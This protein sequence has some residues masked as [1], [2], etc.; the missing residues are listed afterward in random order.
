[1]G[2]RCSGAAVPLQPH[3]ERLAAFCAPLLR[4]EKAEV[5]RKNLHFGKAFRQESGQNES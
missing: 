1:M 4:Y 5:Q 2:G 3:Q